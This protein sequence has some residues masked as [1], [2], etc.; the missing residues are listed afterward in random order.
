MSL[1]FVQEIT[2]TPIAY[3]SAAVFSCSVDETIQ[4]VQRHSTYTGQLH[5]KPDMTQPQKLEE[6]ASQLALA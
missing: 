1:H 3:T 6:G 5:L 2:Q 4:L